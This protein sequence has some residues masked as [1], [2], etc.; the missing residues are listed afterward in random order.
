MAFFVESNLD[1]KIW[2]GDFENTTALVDGS[3]VFT[4]N[5]DA[6]KS[7]GAHKL[8]ISALNVSTTKNL[9]LDLNLKEN[10]AP[11]AISKTVTIGQETSY[12]LNVSELFTDEDGHTLEYKY[13]DTTS[14]HGDGL[15]LESDGVSFNYSITN[16]D[17]KAGEVRFLF[18]ASDSLLKTNAELILKVAEYSSSDTALEVDSAKDA[19]ESF[20]LLMTNAKDFSGNALSGEQTISITSDKGD[21]VNDISASFTN[22]SATIIIPERTLTTIGTHELTISNVNVKVAD[23]VSVQ[24]EQPNRKPV[25][26]NIEASAVVGTP[27]VLDLNTVFTDPD[28]DAMTYAIVSNDGDS[29]ADLTGSS[30]SYTGTAEDPTGPV[31]IVVKANDGEMDSDNY[32]ITITVSAE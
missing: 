14:R 25:G 1:G 30:L 3:G 27:Y 5:G 21:R 26:S 24:I 20:N 12:T 10:H 16:E 19:G 31:H 4:I 23:T 6:F 7:F 22:G 18:E 28:D 2:Y 32:T 8:S 29:T 15:K 17:R 9:I 11:T 13:L